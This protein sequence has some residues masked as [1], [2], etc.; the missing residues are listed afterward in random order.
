MVCR[1]VVSVKLYIKN[2]GDGVLDVPKG[3]RK[4]Q[5]KNDI[6][7]EGF[8]A[9]PTLIYRSRNGR[10]QSPSPTAHRKID[11]TFYKGTS[12]TP[13]PTVDNQFYIDK[14]LDKP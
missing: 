8:H 6:V 10:G 7:G 1:G 2:V 4:Y 13:S 3:L 14:E 9:L 11:I 12:R 5:C